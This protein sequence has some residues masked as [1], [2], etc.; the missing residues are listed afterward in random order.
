MKI[1]RRPLAFEWDRGNRWKNWKK[2]AVTDEECEEVLFDPRK[3]IVKDVLHSRTE[4][5]YLLIGATKKQ[6]PLFVVFTLRD[7]RVRVISARDLNRRERHL[8]EETA[9]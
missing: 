7:H 5:R 9:T 2:H 8:Y 1:L 4:A 3:R 6:R